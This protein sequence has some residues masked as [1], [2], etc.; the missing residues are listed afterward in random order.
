MKDGG[1]PT[2]RRQSTALALLGDAGARLAEARQA[3]ADLVGEAAG[4]DLGGDGNRR[5]YLPA[6]ERFDGALHEAAVASFRSAEDRETM[7]RSCLIVS[8]LY[9]LLTISEPIREYSVT[10]ETPLPDG[11]TVGRWWREHGLGE[12]LRAYLSQSGVTDVYC[13]LSA[14]GIA[15]L[16][17]L[18]LEGTTVHR[19]RLCAP[20]APLRRSRATRWPG[21]SRRASAPALR[22]TRCRPPRSD[23]RRP[24]AATERGCASL[25]RPR[26]PAG[27]RDTVRVPRSCAIPASPALERPGSEGGRCGRT[28]ALDGHVGVHQSMNDGASLSRPA[29]RVTVLPMER[30]LCRATSTDC[31]LVVSRRRKRHGRTHVGHCRDFKKAG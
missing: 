4:P 17:R 14:D 31:M 1:D 20:A 26:P 21:W 3:L 24:C 12:A 15:A 30:R 29:H 25:D 10:M 13:F 6:L 19:G 22:A 28:P 8:G 23:R 2:W 18:E 16:D 27:S 11:Q 7:R 5:A 9:G